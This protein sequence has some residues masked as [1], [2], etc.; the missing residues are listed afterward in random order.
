M[1]TEPTNQ[2]HICNVAVTELALYI[3]D[4]WGKKF[5]DEPNAEY[6]LEAAELLAKDALKSR[7]G[8]GFR[9]IQEAGVAIEQAAHA[10]QKTATEVLKDKIGLVRGRSCGLGT[11][12]DS[13]QVP[14]PDFDPSPGDPMNDTDDY[15]SVARRALAKLDK[16][17]SIEFVLTLDALPTAQ[18][19]AILKCASAHEK[20]EEKDYVNAS[21]A[22]K[23]Y[24]EIEAAAE[25]IH[26]LFGQ[27]Y[28]KSLV[29]TFVNTLTDSLG[30]LQT[31]TPVISVS[32]RN[33]K[34]I[35]D[36]WRTGNNPSNQEARLLWNQALEL[37]R[38]HK[39]F[40]EALSLLDEVQRLD[41]MFLLDVQIERAN[42]YHAM[43]EPR[44][45][46]RIELGVLELAKL[47]G[48][49]CFARLSSNLS[50][51]FRLLYKAEGRKPHLEK[52]LKHSE[53]WEMCPNPPRIYNR[54][55]VL[56]KAHQKLGGATLGTEYLQMASCVIRQ[57][58]IDCP[59][60]MVQDTITLFLTLQEEPLL[61]LW[62][63][64]I[65]TQRNN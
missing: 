26:A 57:V 41:P 20:L 22:R 18:R 34:R 11:E 1:Y 59:A 54:V 7:P 40:V 35:L 42:I 2:A 31:Q 6:V 19:N 52:A 29:E 58:L 25:N 32:E 10:R 28:S 50:D 45:A 55:L 12:L 30:S 46:L 64:M 15:V 4:A 51:T 38:V 61:E 47:S 48:K 60:H 9:T 62:S 16:K 17:K 44:Q 3:V 37:Y 8:D 24:P 63:Y 5:Y 56:S 13:D 23:K 39:Q 65:N 36:V 49:E 53:A 43:E 33:Q 27:F 14:A 21:H